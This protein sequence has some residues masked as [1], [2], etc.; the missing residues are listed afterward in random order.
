MAF[1]DK[2]IGY[3]DVSDEMD[4]DYVSE[5]FFEDEEVIQSYQFIRDQ[6][7]LTNYGIYEVDVQ[8]ITGKKVEVK[9]FPRDTIKTISFE[10]AGTLDMD[11]DIKIGVS[12]NTVVTAEGA[13]YSA[14]L[15]FKVPE[16]QAEEAKEI[17]HLVKA[18]YLF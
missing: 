8:G 16:S 15:S 11:V 13:A 9:F 2:V 3:G 6:I 7:I 5:F 4:K 12:H 10:T 14:P 1:L 17:V 18:H